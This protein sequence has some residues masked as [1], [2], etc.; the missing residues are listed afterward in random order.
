MPEHELDRRYRQ[1][2]SLGQASGFTRHLPR[3]LSPILLIATR[4]GE[5]AGAARGS[6]ARSR[7][8]QELLESLEAEDSKRSEN[9]AKKKG[10]K[11][12]KAAKRLEEQL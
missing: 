4:D 12:K 8:E 9:E 11:E 10:K 7:A 3:G 1:S 2:L 5:P 6:V